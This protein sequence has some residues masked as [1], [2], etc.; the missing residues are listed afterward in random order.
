[1]ISTW[2]ER[3]LNVQIDTESL[4]EVYENLDVLK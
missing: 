4:W 1:M 2:W 3:L